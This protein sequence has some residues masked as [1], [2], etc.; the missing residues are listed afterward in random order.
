MRRKCLRLCGT[1]VRFRIG[2]DKDEQGEIAKLITEAQLR[3]R[4]Q[5]KQK[6]QEETRL[7]EGQQQ[8]QMLME[9]EQHV[10]YDGEET[11]TASKCGWNFVV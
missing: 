4:E 10:N 5:Q 2:R 9:E 8:Q 11:E 3:D 7:Q 1:T 6:Q